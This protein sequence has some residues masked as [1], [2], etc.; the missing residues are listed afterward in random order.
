MKNRT[1]II[2]IIVFSRGI[3]FWPVKFALIVHAGFIVSYSFPAFFLRV[4]KDFAVR[5]EFAIA[6]IARIALCVV[7]LFLR[8]RIFVLF[9]LLLL[10]L[11]VAVV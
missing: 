9:T 8:V 10:V 3:D 5:T 6:S 1:D 7:T 11:S 2:G 4:I